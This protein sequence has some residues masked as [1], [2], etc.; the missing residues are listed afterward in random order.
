[1]KATGDQFR[2][3]VRYEIPGADMVAEHRGHEPMATLDLVA[4]KIER[5][6]RKRK[7]ARLAS[8]V[9]RRA[10]ARRIAD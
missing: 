4:E 1:M 6:L 2:V 10:R 8:R 5:L 3:L 7:T 9:G